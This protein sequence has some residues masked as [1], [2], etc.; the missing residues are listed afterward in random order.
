MECPV[1]S[2]TQSRSLGNSYCYYSVVIPVN[3]LKTKH[4]LSCNSA[5]G[6]VID[7]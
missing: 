4:T 5:V 3:S 1:Q 7:N 2:L 6:S